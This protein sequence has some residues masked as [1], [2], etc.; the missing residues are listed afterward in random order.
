M[1]AGDLR[2]TFDEDPDRYARARP[3]YP[4]ALV[5]AI[6]D[7]LPPSPRILELGP[8]TGQLTAALLERGARVTAVEIG[9]RF[10]AHL[11]R[12]LPT[13]DVMHGEFE[14]AALPLETFDAVVVAT[15]Y[16]WIRERRVER[17]H[18]LLVL[19]G[20]FGVIDLVQVD[21]PVDQGYFDRVT[22]IYERFGD[23]SHRQ[24]PVRGEVRPVIADEVA[25]SDCFETPLVIEV[26]WDQ[27]YSAAQYR[28]LL[29]TYSGTLIRPPAEREALVDALVEVIDDEYDGTLTRPLVAALT[30]AQKPD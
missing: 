25:A 4:D 28:D 2:A 22:P 13:V 6:F 17:P 15:A 26:D 3:T 30:L 7:R 1:A 16:H 19:G 21:D 12:T 11:Q 29:M 10:I 23:R 18:E 20:W 27:T 5:D 9:E 14:T 8:G 24:L